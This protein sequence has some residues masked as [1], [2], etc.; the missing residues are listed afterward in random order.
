MGDEGVQGGGGTDSLSLA[1]VPNA[2]LQSPFRTIL[3]QPS[4]ILQPPRFMDAQEQ[5]LEISIKRCIFVFSVFHLLYFTQ[6]L[7]FRSHKNTFDDIQLLLDIEY[8]LQR[9]RQLPFRG[10]PFVISYL[11]S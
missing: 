2:K 3:G 1:T 5:P 6:L 9:H 7:F 8:W 10:Q 11:R 4:P